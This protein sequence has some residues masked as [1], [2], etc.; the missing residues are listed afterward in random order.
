IALIAAELARPDRPLGLWDIIPVLCMWTVHVALGLV[1][2]RGGVAMA[3]V[4]VSLT[5]GI[6][7][8]VNAWERPKSERV[9]A[10]IVAVLLPGLAWG[11]MGAWRLGR[12][13]IAI[14]EAPAVLRSYDES[15]G[16]AGLV[17]FW[18]AAIALPAGA[19]L[20]M[21]LIPK[22]ASLPSPGSAGLVGLAFVSI[23]PSVVRISS[24]GFPSTHAYTAAVP[25]VVFVVAAIGLLMLLVAQAPLSARK[26]LALTCVGGLTALLA[27]LSVAEGL[28]AGLVQA[29]IA[30]AAV[31]VCL[32]V[33]TASEARGETT[34]AAPAWW[35]WSYAAL[36]PILVAL[37]IGWLGSLSHSPG[38][39][40]GALVALLAVAFLAAAARLAWQL[41]GQ[42]PSGET[43]G[44]FAAARGWALGTVVLVEVLAIGVPLALVI[45]SAL[46]WLGDL[47]G[48]GALR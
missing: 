2:T 48:G 4:L 40:A 33:T 27:C 47:P 17:R 16:I 32:V 15:I 18:L 3:T 23:V 39:R 22:R 1:A 10:T 8:I 7:L 34:S 28:A 12:L 36:A 25:K 20:A 41:L 14:T 43:T 31:S 19:I 37:P 38:L 11:L 46:A 45:L 26:R 6:V 35:P 5:A 13:D 21:T 29:S 42:R 24:D 44:R 30:G 9:W